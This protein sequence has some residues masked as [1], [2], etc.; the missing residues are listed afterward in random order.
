[1][2]LCVYVYLCD[3][4]ANKLINF[5]LKYFV[6]LWYVPVL[7][8]QSGRAGIQVESLEHITCVIPTGWYPWLQVMVR[9]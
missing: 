3:L 9:L 8:T 7:P 6:A 1:M 5:L 2:P 4:V